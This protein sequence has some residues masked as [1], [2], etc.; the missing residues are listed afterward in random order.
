MFFLL[1]GQPACPSVH[2]SAANPRLGGQSA[3][4]PL[5]VKPLM[6]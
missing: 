4:L 5:Y 1:G 2:L 3:Q 6:T